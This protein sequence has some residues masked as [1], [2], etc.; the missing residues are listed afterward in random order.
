MEMVSDASIWL[1]RAVD[2][3]D[4][5]RGVKFATYASFAIAKNFAR[6]RVEQIGRRERRMVTGQDEML[7]RLGARDDAAGGVPD[8]VEALQLTDQLAQLIG[9]L[10]PRER[11]L[12]TAHYGLNAGQP[13]LSLAQ[14]GEKLGIT[15]ARVRQLETRALRKLRRLLEARSGVGPHP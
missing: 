14:L 10:P 9:R 5:A 1:M 8:Q 3:F 6:A 7:N 15:K 12:L 11:E 13:A 4:Y 2:L